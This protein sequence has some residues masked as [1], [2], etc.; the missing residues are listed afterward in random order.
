VLAHLGKEQEK[1][2]RSQKQTAYLSL[3][4]GDG[5]EVLLGLDELSLDGLG[6]GGVGILAVL[7]VHAVLSGK[8]SQD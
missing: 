1:F 8:L 5:G 2:T 3:L 4:C 6:S 7:S